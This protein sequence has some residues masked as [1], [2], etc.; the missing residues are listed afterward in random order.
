MHSFSSM[1]SSSRL[2]KHIWAKEK[3][4][5]L[6]KCLIELVKANGWRS[7]N[8]TFRPRYHSRLTR[9]MTFKMLGRN[10]QPTTIDGRIK[11]LKRTFHTV[12]KMHGPSYSGFRWNNEL[13][14]IIAEKNVFE[15]WVK[16]HYSLCQWLFK[17]N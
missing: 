5:T 14:C 1:V 4:T 15:D 8:E 12:V 6:V 13:K 9:I 16:V 11:L 7:D 17:Y 3:E 10:I 2:P